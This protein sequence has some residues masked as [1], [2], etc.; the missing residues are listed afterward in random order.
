MADRGF[1]IQELSEPRGATLYIPQFPGKCKQ[2]T[3]REVTE[4][5]R[6]AELCVHEERAI[7]RTKSY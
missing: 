2:L 6:I 7:G 1:E 3:L 4:T 5:Q